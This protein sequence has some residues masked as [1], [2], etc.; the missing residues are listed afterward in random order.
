MSG[1]DIKKNLINANNKL[2]KALLGFLLLIPLVIALYFMKILPYTMEEIWIICGGIL[3]LSVCPYFANKNLYNEFFLSSVHLYCLELLLLILAYNPVIN[4]S[5]VYFILPIVSLIYLNRTI[6]HKMSLVAFGGMLLVK[7]SKIGYVVVNGIESGSDL[8]V[9][10]MDLAILT[11]ELIIACIVLLKVYEIME[12][13]FSE[14]NNAAMMEM[15][16][17]SEQVPIS[18]PSQIKFSNETKVEAGDTYDVQQLFASI[19]TDMEALIRGKEKSFT[20]DLDNQMPVALFGRK[21]QLKNALTNICSDLLMYNTQSEV[22]VYVTYDNGINPRKKDNITMI[23]RIDS[24]TVLNKSAAD[25]KALG[26]FLSKRIIDELEGDLVELAGENGKVTYKIRLLQRVEDDVTIAERRKNQ[27]D[28]VLE[29]RQNAILNKAEENVGNLFHSDVHVLICDDNKEARKLLE[30][31]L[32]AVGVKVT[33][34]KSGV[35]CIEFLKDQVYDLVM[36]DQMMP[37]K[38]GVETL[39][40]IRFYDNEYYQKLPIVM[41]SVHTEEEKK[42]CQELGFTDCVAKPI[43][44]NEVKACLRRWVKDDYRMSYEEYVRIQNEGA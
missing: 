5:F 16:M 2:S 38:S 26:Y 11:V 37:D 20:L 27:R 44:V 39:K 4:L 35:E 13:I 34:A 28:E 17:A 22:N 1:V 23:I 18:Q 24:N 7:G 19:A 15:Y 40:E 6:I 29:L 14:A 30:S 43:N 12:G 9:R 41:M 8:N 42:G 10:Y 32:T 25:K 21:V 33:T 31:V 36:I 3:L